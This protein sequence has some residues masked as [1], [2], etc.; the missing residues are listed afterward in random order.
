VDL[1]RQLPRQGRFPPLVRRQGQFPPLVRRQVLVL[2]L[3][4]PCLHNVFGDGR[5]PIH[6]EIVGH[7]RGRS[8]RGWAIELLIESSFL[9]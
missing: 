2:Q 3:A 4:T 9:L 1:L 8:V 7:N 5:W 6:W